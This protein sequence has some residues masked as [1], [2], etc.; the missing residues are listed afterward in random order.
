M[1][2]EKIDTDLDFKEETAV[3]EDSPDEL[4]LPKNFGDFI[5]VERIGRGSFGEVF[6]AENSRTGSTVAVKIPFR[7]LVAEPADYKTVVAEARNATQLNHSGIVR[8]FNVE[9]VDRIPV[10][11]SEFVP[12]RTSRN[13]SPNTDRFHYEKPSTWSSRFA[14]PSIMRITTV[15]SIETLNLR[16]S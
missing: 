12:A 6:R 3:G 15:S 10:L 5:L 16:T 4:D 13:I 14:M 8:V 9:F 7:S 2:L 11:V 1:R